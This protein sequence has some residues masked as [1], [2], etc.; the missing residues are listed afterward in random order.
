MAVELFG[1]LFLLLLSG[2]KLL[3]NPDVVVVVANV[4][5]V[6]WD[7]DSMSLFNAAVASMGVL[8]VAITHAGRSLVLPL[9]KAVPNATS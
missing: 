8:A 6:E 7:V 1:L 2:F 9:S 3:V 5:V 4:V